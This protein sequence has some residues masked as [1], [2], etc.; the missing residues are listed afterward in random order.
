MSQEPKIPEPSDE[1]ATD[2]VNKIISQNKLTDE[3]SLEKIS[4]SIADFVEKE[5]PEFKV[6]YTHV[7]QGVNGF[8]IRDA[9]AQIED[10]LDW[11]LPFE[12][13]VDDSEEEKMLRKYISVTYSKLLTLLD[14][15]NPSKYSDYL[16]EWKLRAFKEPPKYRVS[17]FGFWAE[18]I[19]KYFNL[20]DTSNLTTIIKKTLTFFDVLFPDYSVNF[21]KYK[22][23]AK[24]PIRID[25]I[26]DDTLMWLSITTKIRRLVFSTHYHILKQFNE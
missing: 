2:W 12:D 19:I 16:K 26:D 20:T 22:D 18:K 25:R 17:V 4:D 13:T 15:A 10:P 6:T 9:K 7:D 23:E 14:I 1:L 11:L 21:L 24:F 3:S 5:F 8:R